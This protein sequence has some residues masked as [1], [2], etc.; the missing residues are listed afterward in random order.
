MSRRTLPYA[1]LAPALGLLVLTVVLPT[2]AVVVLALFRVD[3][4]Q[5]DL[6]Y[7]GLEQVRTAVAGPE[8][9]AGVT[10]TVAF[11]TMTV[12]IVVPLGLLVALSIDALS[13]GQAL[14]RAVF[15]LPYA[16]TLV[17]MA[18]VWRWMFLPGSG[19][20]DQIFSDHTGIT[21]WLNSFTWALPAVALVSNWHLLGF[22]VV[23]FLAGM[24]GVSRDLLEAARLDGAGAWNRFWHVTW[25]ALGPATVFAVMITTIL[26]LRTFDTIRVMTNGGP[27]NE[28]ATLTFLLWRRGIE[29]ADIGGA[30]VLTIALLLLVLLAEVGQVRTFARRLE[31]TGRR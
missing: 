24:T 30:A 13:H 17:A 14:W 9:R 22:V 19:I 1:L 25:P 7:V 27:A 8:F 18:A 20:I 2:L 28:T 16:S 21:G 4:L 26:S 10:N 29:F 11:T 12:P 15:F 5:S 3:L 23:I 6:D 31:G